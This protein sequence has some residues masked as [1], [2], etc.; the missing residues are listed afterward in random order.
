MTERTTTTTRSTSRGRLAA[1]KDAI[2]APTDIKE[3]A[4]KATTEIKQGAAKA[5]GEIKGGAAK[6]ASEIKEGAA[7]AAGGVMGN[8]LTLG[9]V[10]AASGFAVGMIVP[11]TPPETQRLPE[12]A[13][14]VK[15][16][17]VESIE[18]TRK[19]G[20][21]TAADQIE[22]VS[23]AAIGA[24]TEHAKKI[25][26]VAGVAE[27]VEQSAKRG[28]RRVARTVREKAGS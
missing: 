24:L 2:P 19:T 21:I 18:Q 7:K 6:A 16:L 17:T 5:A 10:S 28:A 1:V 9:L 27:K 12:L 14:R 20:M 3:G 26:A 13:G 23:D 4:A 11:L 8:P 15:E 25:P 22:S